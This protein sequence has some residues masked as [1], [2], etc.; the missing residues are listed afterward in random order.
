MFKSVNFFLFSSIL[1][2]T[3]IQESQACSRVLHTDAPAT[4]VGRNMD[5]HQDAGVRMRVYPRGLKRQGDAKTHEMQWHSNYGSVVLEHFEED[6]PSLG[7]VAIDGINEKGFSAEVNSLL[8]S[9]YGQRDA[10]RPGLGVRMWAQFYIDQFSSVAEAVRYTE[11]HPLQIEPFFYDKLGIWIG[12]HLSMADASGD[13]AVIEYIKGDLHIYHDKAYRVMTNDPTYDVQL[14]SLSD[15]TGLGGDK[16]LPGSTDANDRFI[17][18]SYYEHYLQ[19]SQSL[20]EEVNAVLTILENAAQPEGTA[21]P[22][23]P[24]LSKTIWRV[25]ADLSHRSYYFQSKANRQLISIHL[26]AFNFD[27]G[28]AIKSFIPAEHPDATGDVSSFF[29]DDH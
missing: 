18:A 14:K 8:S 22:E 23:R 10:A 16:K 19:A 25:I 13:S 27:Q 2:I 15:Y 7:F 1:S 12:L 3:A 9:D 4:L 17:R 20:N 29:Y 6:A 24:M 21:R 26:D 11:S 5:W 28:T